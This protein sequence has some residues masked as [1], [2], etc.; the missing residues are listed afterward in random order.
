MP[1]QHIWCVTVAAVLLLLLLL[2]GTASVDAQLVSSTVA[3]FGFDNDFTD[4]LGNY[5]FQSPPSGITIQNAIAAWTYG[6]V[7]F[8]G[9]QQGLQFA[10]SPQ[11][12]GQ[13]GHYVNSWALS[14]WVYVT[15][16][17]VLNPILTYW[18]DSSH[19]FFSWGVQPTSFG[20]T[21]VLNISLCQ[22]ATGDD[23]AVQNVIAYNGTIPANKWTHVAVT[24][25]SRF[26]GQLPQFVLYINGTEAGTATD[27][28]GYVYVP[29]QYTGNS[30]SVGYQGQYNAAF[31][32]NID[33]LWVFSSPPGPS[34]Q[35]KPPQY[36]SDPH[37]AVL[38]ANNTMPCSPGSRS[39]VNDATEG[40]SAL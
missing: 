38:A 22:D 32:G 40:V 12:V 35:A 5:T 30:W 34:S 10:S 9:N 33:E 36:F 4:S 27:K 21:Q 6:A 24:C 16:T 31:Q 14:T 17:N 11:F 18:P 20:F 3:H 37:A 23:C 26:G 1:R 25:I 28:L 2:A 39:K 13:P 29:T 7:Q 19:Q 8:S 15:N